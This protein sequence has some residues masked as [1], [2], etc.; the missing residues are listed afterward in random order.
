MDRSPLPCR[1]AGCLFPVTYFAYERHLRSTAGRS[2]GAGGCTAQDEERTTWEY[3]KG[4]SS[5]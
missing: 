1:E 3:C 5:V 2:S 4:G